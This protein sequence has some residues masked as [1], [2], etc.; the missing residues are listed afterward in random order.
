MEAML[1][2]PVDNREYYL[3]CWLAGVNP[4]DSITDKAG[5]QEVL[6]TYLLA[7][8]MEAEAARLLRASGLASPGF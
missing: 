3:A 8:M 5:E 6:K 7:S 1:S 2:D 4:R